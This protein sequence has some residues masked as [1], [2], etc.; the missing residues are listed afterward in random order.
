VPHTHLHK[1]QPTAG[2]CILELVIV[3]KLQYNLSAER[4]TGIVLQVA[5][6]LQV[7][8]QRAYYDAMQQ[9]NTA[10]LN[11]CTDFKGP[12]YSRVSREQHAWL[13]VLSGAAS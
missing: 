13:G 5:P 11:V 3:N 4:V 8:V 9:L 12:S 7:A 6:A 2:S 10:L 1:Q